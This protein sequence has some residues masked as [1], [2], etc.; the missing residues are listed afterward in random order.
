MIF[1]DKAPI[2]FLKLIGGL[3]NQLFQFA[4]GQHV[5]RK[6]KADLIVDPTGLR[7]RTHIHEINYISKLYPHVYGSQVVAPSLFCIEKLLSKVQPGGLLAKCSL[8]DE[9]PLPIHG[10]RFLLARG[11][12]QDISLFTSYDNMVLQSVVRPLMNLPGFTLGFTSLTR[13]LCGIHARR[14]DYVLDERA[15]HRHGA[16]SSQ[17]YIKAALYAHQYSKCNRYIVFS[18]DSAWA[19][20]WIV[21]PLSAYFSASLS[22]GGNALDDLALMAS[23]PNLILS[24]S[25][26]SW[27]AGF[28][29]HCVNDSVVF[30]P[31][32][33]M[34][35]NPIVQ[36]GL[37]SWIELDS[38]WE[39]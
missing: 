3:G 39:S 7:S 22:T 15:R 20:E 28:L 31:R 6:L 38:L 36:M 33:W 34:R 10:Y 30:I 21:K 23:C 24:N 13:G 17:Y 37:P 1:Y 12:W 18:D 4:F 5:S 8:S 9:N 25:T 29:A 19:E 14:G 26:F 16:L 2:V 11:Y 27:W 32:Q 35:S